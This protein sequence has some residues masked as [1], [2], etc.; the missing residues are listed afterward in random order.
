MSLVNI[1]IPGMPGNPKITKPAQ[2]QKQTENNPAEGF[3]QK[4]SQTGSDSVEESAQEQ[5]LINMEM[6]MSVSPVCQKDG[7]QYAFV[8]F[9]ANDES[10]HAA[11]VKATSVKAKMAEGR[12]PEC[13]IIHNDGFD[14][15]EV[16]FLETYMKRELTRLK[17]MASSVSVLGAFMKN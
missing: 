17:K 1:D 14:E 9:V 13:K 7:K 8:T 15:A 3:V 5:N 6:N 12:I 2:K 4:R 10:E 11:S 16:L